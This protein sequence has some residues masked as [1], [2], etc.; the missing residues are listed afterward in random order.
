LVKGNGAQIHAIEATCLT[1]ISKCVRTRQPKLPT[2]KFRGE[3]AR[4]ERSR[5][6]FQQP[7][8]SSHVSRRHAFFALGTVV[9]FAS[10]L[11]GC[12]TQ[13][14]KRLPVTGRITGLGAEA[15][16]GSISFI[17]S[18][19]NDGLG[20]TAALKDGSYSF[21]RTDGPTAGQYEV[22]IRR[23]PDK[24]AVGSASGQSKQEWTFHA[25]IPA[26]GPYT[27]DFQLD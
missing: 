3:L 19:G 17:P 20:A 23:T 14:G 8:M 6:P 1:A 22:S 4:S 16:D 21:D 7:A 5:Q 25:E 10:A 12:G 18:K 11:A 2:A 15:F 27:R 26:D 13:G 24:A 9:L